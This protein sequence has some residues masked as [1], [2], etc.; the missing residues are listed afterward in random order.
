MAQAGR[1]QGHPPTC[2]H[3]GVVAAQRHIHGSHNV[4]LR[5][6]R[7]RHLGRPHPVTSGA[8]AQLSA[9]VG[10]PRPQAAGAQGQRGCVL[11][12]RA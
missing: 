2:Q 9:G 11:P 1:V 4:S 8:H 10:A 3:H 12:G 6:V 7:E 5:G